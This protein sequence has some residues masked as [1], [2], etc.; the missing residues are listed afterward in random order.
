MTVSFRDKLILLSA[1][2]LVT[3]VAWVWI[4][5]QSQG[6]E[7]EVTIAMEKPS[8]LLDAALF[9]SMWTVM[10]AG[11]MFPSVAPILLMFS[12]ISRRRKTR[13]AA[14]LSTSVF[15]SGYALVMTVTG[16]PAYT[17]YRTVSPVTGLFPELQGYGHIVGGILLI[18]AGLYQLSPLKYACLSRCRSPLAFI[19]TNWREGYFGSLSMGA[20]YGAYC[21]A[22]CWALMLV[23]FPVGIM[24]LAWMG[25]ITLVIFLEKT[26]RYG[27]HIGRIA[28]VLLLLLGLLMALWPGLLPGR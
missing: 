25:V 19:M 17:G 22:C 21:M 26:S 11:M 20:K 5:Y 2:A 14:F 23:M 27:F 13:N 9:L 1:L 24:N 28:G 3:A 12:N 8:L 6:M 15:L 4:I 18:A 16:I 10:M 7:S